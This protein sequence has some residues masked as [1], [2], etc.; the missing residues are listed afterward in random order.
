MGRDWNSVNS[1]EWGGVMQST[2]GG[3][4]WARLPGFPAI[5]YVSSIV[6]L[7]SRTI[8]VAARSALNAVRSIVQDGTP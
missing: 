6:A 8:L 2:D 3:D 7:P 5:Y 1:G 4:S